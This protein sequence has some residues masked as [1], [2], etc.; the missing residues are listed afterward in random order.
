MRA[1]CMGKGKRVQCRSSSVSNVQC[2]I[3]EIFEIEEN[4]EEKN[5]SDAIEEDDENEEREKT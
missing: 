5:R 4:A 1:W 3:L 2:G